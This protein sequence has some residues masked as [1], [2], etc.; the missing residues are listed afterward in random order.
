[1]KMKAKDSIELDDEDFLKWVEDMDS[2]DK[3]E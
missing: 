2:L 1:M 3:K